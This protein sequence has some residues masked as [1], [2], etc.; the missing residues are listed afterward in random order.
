ME[1]GLIALDIDGTLTGADHQIPLEVITYLHKLYEHGW[2]IILV[3]GRMYSFAK[4]EADKINFPYYLA[5]QNGAD[6]LEM[7]NVKLADQAYFGL[8]VV[9]LLDELYQNIE[10]DF[11]IYSGYKTGDFCYYRSKNFPSS[12]TS[13]LE[14]LE[15]FSGAP[16]KDCQDFHFEG[17]TFPLI[18]CVGFFEE[19]KLVQEKLTGVTTSLIKDPIS[20]GFYHLILVTHPDATKGRA[21]RR[22]QKHLNIEGPIIAAGD[23]MNDVP[24]LEIADI[25]IA[26]ETAPKEVLSHGQIIAKPSTELGIISAL[27][28][29]IAQC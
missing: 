4:R 22:I 5:V 25:S 12:M 13:Y 14:K 11:L 28:T 19:L 6:I 26:M 20:D 9:Q 10:S 3:T 2:K 18:K 17:Q 8:D 27:E 23:D 1:H 16:W 24:M 21:L 15:S 7:P 29:A